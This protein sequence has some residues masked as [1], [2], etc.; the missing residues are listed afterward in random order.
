MNGRGASYGREEARI[1]ASK[2]KCGIRAHR[3]HGGRGVRKIGDCDDDVSVHVIQPARNER[4][5]GAADTESPVRRH[6]TIFHPRLL[7]FSDAHPAVAP[8]RRPGDVHNTRSAETPPRGREEQCSGRSDQRRVTDPLPSSK[9]SEPNRTGQRHP[10]SRSLLV[11]F[12]RSPSLAPSVSFS[13]HLRA[14]ADG[15]TRDRLANGGDDAL[16]DD[17]VKLDR[18]S[19][20]ERDKRT[21]SGFLGPVTLPH[22]NTLPSEGKGK[23]CETRLPRQRFLTPLPSPSQSLPFLSRGSF[24]SRMPY[25]PKAGEDGWQ[26]AQRGHENRI[27][28]RTVKQKDLRSTSSIRFPRRCHVKSSRTLPDFFEQTC[29]RFSPRGAPRSQIIAKAVERGGES[30]ALLP[31]LRHRWRSWPPEPEP[32]KGRQWAGAKERRQT[33]SDRPHTSLP[34]LPSSLLSS[35]HVSALE[36]IFRP[37]SLKD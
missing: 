33:G 4:A 31:I 16:L 2:P 36:E 15:G 22:Q 35:A 7:H 26:A 13:I 19:D 17:K 6:Y 21:R 28:G 3:H 14:R 8:H 11:W 12:R 30:S 1:G 34:F 37:L 24:S 32:G 10:R 25:P 9:R 5:P 29:P 23:R 18:I 27:T 20:R